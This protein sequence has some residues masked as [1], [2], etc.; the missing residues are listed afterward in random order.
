MHLYSLYI[1]DKIIRVKEATS[2]FIYSCRG[3]IIKEPSPDPDYFISVSKEEI[4]IGKMLSES[5]GMNQVA[6]GVILRKLAMWLLEKERTL[7]I[8]GS[9]VAYHG[10]AYL[11]TAPSGTGK[12]THSRLWIKNLPDA[13]ILNGDK[14][15]VSTGE[16]IM[17]WGSPWCGSERYNRNEGVELK[18][19]CFLKRAEKNLITEITADEAIPL[20]ASQTGDPDPDDYRT[21]IWM[22]EALEQFRGRVKFYRYEMNNLAKEEA[23]HTTYDVLSYL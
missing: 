11:F 17:A 23:F 16:K 20:L 13:Y 5:G 1:C 18:A 21:K 22:M 3:Y 14:P 2:K 10:A 15:F 9:V 7:F 19:I 4:E 12:T 6:S 8:H